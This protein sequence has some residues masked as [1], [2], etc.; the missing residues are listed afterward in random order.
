MAKDLFLP[1]WDREIGLLTHLFHRRTFMG[2]W[3]HLQRFRQSLKRRAVRQSSQALRGRRR[4]PE[5]EHLED[6]LVPTTTLFLD[7]G[8]GLPSAGLTLT[9]RQ[10]RDTLN[11]PDLT[12]TNITPTGGGLSNTDTV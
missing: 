3:Q 1:Y 5:L 4:R 12:Q 10:L 6:R 8:E 9:V 2:F 11:G 7:F